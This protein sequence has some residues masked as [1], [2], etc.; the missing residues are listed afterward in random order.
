MLVSLI[1]WIRASVVRT[2]VRGSQSRVLRG[3]GKVD[4]VVDGTSGDLRKSVLIHGAEARR[5]TLSFA[6]TTSADD[7]VLR[8]GGTLLDI[9]GAGHD[10]CGEADAEESALEADVGE[11][12]E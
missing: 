2:H 9:N 7:G 10:S 3:V 1:L 4:G 5:R 8:A 12:V 11:H 6:G